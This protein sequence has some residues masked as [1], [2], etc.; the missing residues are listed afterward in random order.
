MDFNTS[1]MDIPENIY[2]KIVLYNYHPLADIFEE[3]NA[4]T[5]ERVYNCFRSEVFIGSFCS[6]KNI[7]QLQNGC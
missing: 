3:H 5:I 7:T 4:S 2:N 1:I 6:L